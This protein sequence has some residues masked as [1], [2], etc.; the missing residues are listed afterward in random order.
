VIL[1]VQQQLRSVHLCTPVSVSGTFLF[2]LGLRPLLATI[3]GITKPNNSLIV[4][5]PKRPIPGPFF[6]PLH[7]AFSSLCFPKTILLKRKNRY[8]ILDAFGHRMVTIV[9]SSFI[10]TYSTLVKT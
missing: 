4:G 6:G 8:M 2:F 9:A 10:T 5:P 3:Y 1:Q 7:F